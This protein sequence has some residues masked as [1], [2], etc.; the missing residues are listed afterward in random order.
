MFIIKIRI[1]KF[2]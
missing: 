1:Q 2:H